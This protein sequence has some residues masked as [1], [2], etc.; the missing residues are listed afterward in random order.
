MKNKAYLFPIFLQ[1]VIISIYGAK[2]YFERYTGKYK[3]YKKKYLKRLLGISKYDLNNQEKELTEFLSK[4]SDKNTYYKKKGVH[5]NKYDLLTKEVLRNNINFI[6]QKKGIKSNTGG[7][8][9]K[10]LEVFFTK[11]DFRKRMA[12]LDAFKEWHGVNL[13]MKAARFSG[14]KLIQDNYN[15]KVFWRT[16]WI[17]KQRLYSTFHMSKDNLIYYVDNLNK[18]KP[19]SLD[20]FITNIYEIA[21]FIEKNKIKLEFTP[22]AIFPTAETVLP[23]HRELVERVFGCPVRDQYASS[24]GAPFIVE[25]PKGKLHYCIDT[26]VI[27]IVGNDPMKGEIA[28]TSFTT[29]GTPLIRYLIGDVIEFSNEKCSCGCNYPIVKEIIGRNTDYLFSKERGIIHAANMS[30]VI[31][32]L[33]NAII[34]I[35]FIQKSEDVIDINVVFD[36]EK[37]KPEYDK[38]IL[39]E[40]NNRL[41]NN[42]KLNIFKVNEIKREKSGKYRFIIN[43]SNNA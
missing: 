27:E 10:S 30:N 7:T 25:C 9:G 26:G 41:G 34:N 40:M 38:S 28:V 4:I 37:Y 42:I 21:K 23:H 39:Y 5:L 17:I 8:T 35:Q 6:S 16:N 43:N 13:G 14:K 12:Y 24:E 15:G 2:L 32:Y 33:P 19:K 29:H 31:K 11:D 18:F 22:I 36:K 1:N 3:L 20:G